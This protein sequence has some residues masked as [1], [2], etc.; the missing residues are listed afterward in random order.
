MNPSGRISSSPRVKITPSLLKWARERSLLDFN[1]LARKTGVKPEVL[2]SWEQGE[3]APTYR[4]AEKL[5]HAL[6][7]PF[8]YLFLSQPPFA[9]SAVPDFRR[10]PESQI[11][12]FSPELESVLNDAK[13]KQAWLHEWRVEEGFSPLPFIGKFS[14]EDSPQTVAEQIRSVLDLP[15]PTA[16]G[17]YSWN[18]HLQKL[19]KHA[20]KAGIAV[21]RNGVVLSDNRRPL[22][23]EEFRGFNLP[24]NYAPVIFINAQDSIAGQIFTLAHELGHLWIGEGGISNPLTSD[25]PLETSETERFCNRVA[26]ELL[27]PQNLFLEHWP[28]GTTTIPEILNAAQQ[29]AREFKVSAPAVLLRACELNRLDAPLFRAAYEEIYRQV[30]PLRKKTSGGNFYATWQA[31]NS[32]TVVTEVLQAL[33][34]GKI[35]YRDAARLLNTNLAILEKALN[36]M[37]TGQR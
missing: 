27:I 17:L 11:G 31:R 32:Q 5:A 23:V 7:I 3:T 8:G 20:E 30:I 34:Q 15:S 24:D 18:E 28:S 6:H 16:K 36:R 33:R 4:Q 21:I 35:L 14:P 37:K 19:V 22:S 9:P 10:L 1:T 2:Q 29:L 26:A 13:R 12:R 25:N